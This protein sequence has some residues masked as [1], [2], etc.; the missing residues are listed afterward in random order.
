[1]MKQLIY[2]VCLLALVSCKDLK[3]EDAILKTDAEGQTVEATNEQYDQEGLP[4]YN[5][6][7][8]N[9]IQMNDDL[10]WEANTETNEG[11]KKMQNTLKSQVTNTLKDYHTLGTQLN[12]DKNYVVKNCTMKGA[13]HDNLH[14]WLMPLITKIKALSET[15]N[16]E[17][18]SKIKHS[19]EENINRYYKYFQ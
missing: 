19:I 7:W 1:M 11:V 9:D 13:S 4:M 8:T 6:S 12:D 14:I 15:K 17:E 2:T 18:A 3:K 16:I 10:K 5:N